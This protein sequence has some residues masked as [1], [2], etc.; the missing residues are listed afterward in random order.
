MQ[1]STRRFDIVIRQIR[2]FLSSIMKKVLLLYQQYYPNGKAILQHGA[3]GAFVE[4]IFLMNPNDIKNGIGVHVTATTSASSKDAERQTKLSLFN[5][6][7]TYYGQLTQYI[8]AAENPQLPPAARESFVAIINALSDF[9]DE[10]LED[11]DVRN[12]YEF[13]QAITRARELASQAAAEGNIAQ[14]A[15][16]RG[17]ADLSGGGEQTTA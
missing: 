4:E 9:V 2:M 12:K 14:L 1:E 16:A 15:G 5:L 3:D 11:F 13:S 6:L 10:I 8:M 17:M 7:T